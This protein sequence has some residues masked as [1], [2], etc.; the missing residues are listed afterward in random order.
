L[1]ISLREVVADPGTRDMAI[2]RLDSDGWSKTRS[3]SQ[4]VWVR[5]ALLMGPVR[6]SILELSLSQQVE[7]LPV[8]IEYGLFFDLLYVTIC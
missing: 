8:R 5:V 7:D 4:A 1:D 2:A 6:E 3:D